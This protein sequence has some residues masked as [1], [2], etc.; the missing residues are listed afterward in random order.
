MAGC[1]LTMS[2]KWIPEPRKGALGLSSVGNDAGSVAP[3]AAA[4][5]VSAAATATAAAAATVPAAPTATTDAAIAATAATGFTRFGFV[6]GQP[7]AVVLLIVEPLDRRLSLGLGIHLD[8]AE[9]LA[10]ARITVLNHLGALH[11]SVLSEP[12]FQVGRGYRVGQVANI[13]FLSHE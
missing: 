12:A 7:T 13:Q 5:A 9:S 10:A 3:T 11:R 2:E 1:G 6:H 8:K 4:A